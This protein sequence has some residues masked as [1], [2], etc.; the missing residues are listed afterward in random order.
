[1]SNSILESYF[2]KVAAV[3]DGASFVKLSRVL[4]L[5]EHEISGVVG[6]TITSLIKFETA[7]VGVFSAIALGLVG[8][9]DKAAQ[10]DQSYRLLGMRM[11]MTKDTFQAFQTALD[12]VGVTADQAA[13]DPESNRRVNELYQRNLRLEGTLGPEFE[14]NMERI[15]DVRMQVKELGRDAQYLEFGAINKL[16]T[17]LGFGGDELDGKLHRLN[18]WFEQNLPQMADKISDFLVPVWKDAILVVQDFGDILKAGAGDFSFLMATLDGD[19]SI[20][21][22]TFSVNNLKKAFEDLLDFVTKSTLGVGV[23]IKS[24]MHY[25]NTMAY[26]GR[27]AVSF[28]H[29]DT[30]AASGFLDK[31]YD[32]FFAGEDDT[33]A[34]HDPAKRDGLSDWAAFQKYKTRKADDSSG[35]PVSNYRDLLDKYSAQYGIDPDYAAATMMSESSGNPNSMSTVKSGS[36]KGQHAYGLFN[37]MPDTAAQYGLGMDQIQDPNRNAEAGIHYLADLLKEFHGDKELAS[38]AYNA[39]SGAVKKYGGVPPY[40]ETQKYVSDV[41]KELAYLQKNGNSKTVTIQNMHIVV[42]PNTPKDDIHAIISKSMKNMIDTS[43]KNEIA[44]TAGGAFY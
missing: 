37:L 17:K 4:K 18:D 12:D 2:V 13:Y 29:G 24:L 23:V 1:M 16:F 34:M 11:L 19:D 30:T 42:P 7:S 10:T 44:Q 31:S 15:R 41:M 5:A 9:A 28:A 39:G 33:A 35:V 36:R 6:S 14:K 43:T 21:D 22:T 40:D 38:A 8:M 3:P 26:I 27:A 32:E 20:K 25:G